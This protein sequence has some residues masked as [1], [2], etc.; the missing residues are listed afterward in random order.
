MSSVV[1]IKP[2]SIWSRHLLA[3]LSMIFGPILMFGMVLF[4]NKME[5][6]T[7]R[8]LTKEVS[9]IAVVKTEVIKQESPVKKAAERPKPKA[10]KPARSTSLAPQLS[11]GLSGLDFGL[12]LGTRGDGSANSKDSSLEHSTDSKSATSNEAGADVSPQPKIKSAFVY[13][14]SAKSKGVSGYVVLS[15]LVDEDGNVAQVEIAE[16]SPPEVFD[17]TALT[18]IKNWRFSPGTRQGKPVKMWIKQKIRFS[19]E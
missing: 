15:V 17:T 4:M 2:R 3:A 1:Q 6:G 12:D 7:D 11:S 5:F 10:S 18:G 13:P 8:N 14:K 19:L 9:E 16:S